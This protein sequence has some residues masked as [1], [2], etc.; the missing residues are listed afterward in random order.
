MRF[1][2]LFQLEKK[3]NTITIEKSDLLQLCTTISSL[4]NDEMLQAT[5]LFNIRQLTIVQL[6]VDLPLATTTFLT[7]IATARRPA[8][9]FWRAAR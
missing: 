7:L 8:D 1:K 3:Q 5:K 2:F 6:V 9:Q 4:T